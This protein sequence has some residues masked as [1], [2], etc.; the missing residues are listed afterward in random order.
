MFAADGGGWLRPLIRHLRNSME[1]AEIE[2]E[3]TVAEETDDVVRIITTHGAMGLGGC[4]PVPA[5]RA[6]TAMRVPPG[7]F[8]SIHN[9]GLDEAQLVICSV[10]IDDPTADVDAK[11]NFWP[12]SN[13]AGPAGA[14]PP[15]Q[16]AQG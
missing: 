13:I 12:D 16:R 15:D 9:D 1:Q 4:P 11:P 14:R 10:K 7:A 8:R 5:A 3:V 6:A 2:I